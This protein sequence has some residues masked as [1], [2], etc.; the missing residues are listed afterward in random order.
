MPPIRHPRTSSGNQPQ[1]P[2]APPVTTGLSLRPRG[3]PTPATATLLILSPPSPM[4]VTP[5]GT[6]VT[7]FQAPQIQPL[8]RYNTSAPLVPQPSNNLPF[9]GRLPYAAQICPGGHCRHCVSATTAGPPG[10]VNPR[11]LYSI[12]GDELRL[13]YP[14][15]S[16]PLPL[17]R[18]PPAPADRL[19][20]YTS[21]LER[22]QHHPDQALRAA[23]MAAYDTA[24]P[25]RCTDPIGF[26]RIGLD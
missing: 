24:L 10:L 20:M 21:L 16:R 13:P 2:S 18:P 12:P 5:A 9:G 7:P 25:H 4:P 23:A 1:R 8:S 14:C 15:R 26:A 11:D 17:P 19:A 3:R 6:T 22:L